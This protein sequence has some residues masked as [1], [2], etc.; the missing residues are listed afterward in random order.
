MAQHKFAVSLNDND[1]EERQWIE[2]IANS[3]MIPAHVLK[4][5][6]RAYF[7]TSRDVDGVVTTAHVVEAIN[8]GFAMLGKKLDNIRAAPIA[9]QV[10][11]EIARQQEV[12]VTEDDLELSQVFVSALK[13]AA[14]PGMRMEEQ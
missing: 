9:R 11:T 7:K 4:E 6:L 10:T 1:A 14:R 5:A 12:E 3:G 8:A 13:K 2:G